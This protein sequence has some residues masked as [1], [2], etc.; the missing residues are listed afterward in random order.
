MAIVSCKFCGQKFDRE[1]LPFIQI[2][3]GKVFRYAHPKCYKDAV[4]NKL[5][6]DGLEICDPKDNIIC[7]ICRKALRKSSVHIQRAFHH[8]GI[9]SKDF[10]PKQ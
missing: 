5:V 3:A 4:A 2:P 7:P 9:F 10:W 6:A 1:Q 8:H